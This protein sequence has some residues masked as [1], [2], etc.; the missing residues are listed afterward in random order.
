MKKIIAVCIVLM[1]ASCLHAQTFKKKHIVRL[2]ENLQSIQAEWVAM[3]PDTLLDF[4]IVGSGADGQTKIVPYQSLLSPNYFSEKATQLTGMKSGYIQLADWNRDNRMDLIVSGKTLINTDAVFVFAGTSNFS[5][6]K[7]AQKLHDHTGGFRVADFDN[8][9]LPDIMVFGTNFIRIYKNKGTSLEEQAV[10]TGITPTDVAVYDMNK[11]GVR[12]FAV[13]GLDQQNNPVTYAYL[14]QQPFKYKRIRANFPISGPLSFADVDENGLFDLIGVGN[15]N[16]NLMIWNNGK[17]TLAQQEPLAAV[18]QASLFTGDIDSDGKADLLISGRDLNGRRANYIQELSG[19]VTKLDTTG[20]ILQRAGDQDRDGDLDLI[21]LIDSIGLQWLKFYENTTPVVNKRPFGAGQSFALSTFDKT[22]IF[23]EAA[24]DDRT[25]KSS[26]TYD[27]WLG[28]DQSNIIVPSFDLSSFRRTA[29]AHGNAGSNSS[30]MIEGLTDDRY[31]YMVQAVDNAYNGSYG[32]GE[33]ICTGRIL[34]CFDLV[35]QDVQTCVGKNVKL[36]GGTGATWYSVSKGLLGI[37]DTLK[38]IAAVTDT[39][40]SFSPQH[41]DCSKHKIYVVNV[42][43]GP[44]SE[45]ETIYACVGSKI[46]LKT[47]AVWKN[48]T[49]DTGPAQEDPSTMSYTVLRADTVTATANG[50]GCS[51]TKTFYIKISEPDI[52]IG[53]EGFQ[54][55]KG[56]SVRL[57]TTGNS[58][59]WLWEPALGL[60][61]TTTEDPIATPPV[62]TEYIVTGADSLG[63]TATARM[64]IIVQETAFVPNLF[65]PNGDG[66]NDNLLVFGIGQVSRFTFKVFTREGSLVYETSEPSQAMGIGWN[67]FVNGARQPAGFYYWKVDGETSNGEKLLLNGKTNGSI[68]LVH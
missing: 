50:Q 68:L 26:I 7:Q 30:V 2:E 63:C 58:V 34:P 4:V 36:P 65:T 18:R 35:H 66:K 61:S 33:G 3:N 5:F 37:A 29:V 11:D 38:F 56:N 14:G 67:G 1:T 51:Y 42:A 44:S 57:V 60:S 53:G 52:E 24:S 9:A 15:N 10:I 8:D 39:I 23:W 64:T 45:Q 43:N 27:V 12:D 31:F 22:F 20:L 16:S 28:T 40:F 41:S 59:S 13:A 17:D 25:H 6:Q 46:E 49:W 54:I 47:P 19:T 32:V 48:V 21:Q 55:M 62:T